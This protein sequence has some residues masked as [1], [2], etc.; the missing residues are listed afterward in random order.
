L[1][2]YGQIRRGIAENADVA[3][4]NRTSESK[5]KSSGLGDG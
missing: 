3:W 2:D 1:S 5:K 4:L